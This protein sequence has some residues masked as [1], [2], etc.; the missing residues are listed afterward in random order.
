MSAMGGQRT[1][2]TLRQSHVARSRRGDT[3]KTI[4]MR[5]IKGSEGRYTEP[6]APTPWLHRYQRS[7]YYST[8]ALAQPGK[9]IDRVRNHAVFDATNLHIEYASRATQIRH[10]LRF[11][12]TVSDAL[13]RHR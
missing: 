6:R 5:C 4:E 10:Y 8:K 3:I 9:L 1:L 12:V 7:A 11:I 13:L 2:S